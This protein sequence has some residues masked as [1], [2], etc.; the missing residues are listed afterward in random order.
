MPETGSTENEIHVAQEL[1]GFAAVLC[2]LCP[3]VFMPSVNVWSHQGEEK[4][5]ALVPCHSGLHMTSFH[6][7][8]A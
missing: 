6:Y 2:L 4:V 7:A 3:N 1:V 8:Y 5:V